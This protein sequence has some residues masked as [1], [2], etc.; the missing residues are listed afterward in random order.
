MTPPVPFLLRAPTAMIAATGIEV[1]TAA[2]K[3]AVVGSTPARLLGR[4]GATCRFSEIS[5][6]WSELAAIADVMVG[7]SS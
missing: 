4:F 2:V 6:A 1:T 3:V 5:F 7:S